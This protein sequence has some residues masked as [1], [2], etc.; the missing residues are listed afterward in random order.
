MN[1]VRRQSLSADLLCGAAGSG[2][3][4]PA[5]Q[6]SRAAGGTLPDFGET[7]SLDPV[8][9]N[10]ATV[11]ERR[12]RGRAARDAAPRKAHG[13][14]VIPP[15]R[16]GA[17]GVLE[18]QGET[19]IPDLLPI[20]Y[21]R[22]AASP[23]AFFRG[24]AAIMAA[25]LAG[26]P[27]SGFAAQ[28]CGDAHLSNFGGFAA[29]DRELVFDLNDF[30]ETFP[31]PWEWDLK[32]LG[33]SVE[34]A[35][36]EAGLGGRERHAAVAATSRAY[37][38]AM[39]DFAEMRNLDV[40]YT[41]LKAD[42][43]L[44]RVREGLGEKAARRLQ[45]QLEKAQ[46]KNSLR[47]LDKLTQRVNG[48]LRLISDPPLL[49]PLSELLPEADA[50]ALTE[51]LTGVVRD[52]TDTLRP[53]LRPVVQSY[54]AVDVARKVVGVGSVGTR[55]WVVLMLGRDDGDPLFLQVKE[56]Q[57]SVLQPHIGRSRYV[58]QGRRVV[59]GQRLM[60]AAGDV[61]LGWIR[62]T[63]V[64]ERERDFYVRQ[65]WDWKLSVAL[66]SFD[67]DGFER[68][69]ALCGGTLARAHAR[70]ADRVAIAAYLGNS[71]AFDQALARFAAAYADTNESDHR[72]LVDAIRSGRVTADA[73]AV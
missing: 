28:L 40:W 72:A 9:A 39:R 56:A 1:R 58:N 46:G 41:R 71:D 59:E 35:S 55:A 66:D 33:A 44:S 68:Y 69:G 65:L 24:G 18:R 67:A 14:W 31:G 32:R 22:M 21:A 73:D 63:G 60:Q 62:T 36:R 2:T 16:P 37:R 20:R 15:G 25:D 17:I 53:D 23:F 4:P 3:P 30:D 29:P 52:Y 48:E 26:T 12:A 34:V 50:A 57:P 10:G 51:A 27:R 7:T 61:L 42:E 70:T 11:E 47:A 6:S 38:E 54:R 8:A 43:I 5:Q 64:G 49:V 19:R 13:E 45:R